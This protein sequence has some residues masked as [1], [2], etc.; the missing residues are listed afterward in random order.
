MIAV[1]VGGRVLGAPVRPGPAPEDARAR[2]RALVEEAGR[3]ERSARRA[4]ARRLYEEALRTLPSGDTEPGAASL[5][6]WIGRT[7]MEDGDAEAATDCFVAAAAVAEASGDGAGV[8][9]AANCR[10]SV[11]F[12]LGRLDEAER[13]W[14]ETRRTASAYGIRKLAAMVEQNLGNVASIQGD[15]EVALTRYRSALHEYRRL[16]LQEYV[17]PLLNNLA[18]ALTDA[19]HWDEAEAALTEGIETCRRAGN[20]SDRVVLE[21]SGARLELRR[22]RWDRARERCEL[23]QELALEAGDRR[24]LGEIFRYYGAIFREL[25][26]PQLARDYLNRAHDIARERGSLLLEAETAREEAQLHRDQGENQAA[27]ERLNRA[28]RLFSELRARHQL[29]DVDRRLRSLEGDF[30]R[31]V[32][33]WGKSLESKDL[34]THG[35]SERVADYACRLAEATGFPAE[36]RVWFRMGALLH[37][38]GKVVVP[39][40]ILNKDGRLTDEEWA[41]MRRHPDEGVR[42]LGDIEFPW[43]VRP[44]IRG[45]HERWDG[46]GYPQGLRGE[47]IDLSAR[48]LCVA[49]VYDA[50]TTDR[51]YRKAFSHDEA[52]EIMRGES[53]TTFDPD[54]LALFERLPL[55]EAARPRRPETVARIGHEPGS[56]APVRLPPVRMTA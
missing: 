4:D 5:L 20:V 47:E 44:M 56:F 13:L 29:A 12:S 41:V 42:L 49:D 25:G 11:A 27:L 7:H 48:I 21:A 36:Y 53:G 3:A 23:A 19:G 54:L 17:G 39:L 24:W 52:L 26:R 38:I 31:L 2:V 40:E 46:T 45:H 34:Y 9:S 50:L 10:A 32:G 30:L 1:P 14:N 8:A 37:D 51:A 33:E 35:H 18:L 55:E 22:G 15:H 6:R 16:G 28:H 43:D